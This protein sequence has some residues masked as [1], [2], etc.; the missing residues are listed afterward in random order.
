[1]RIAEHITKLYLRYPTNG[2]SPIDDNIMESAIV[3]LGNITRFYIGMESLL[4]LDKSEELHSIHFL[5]LIEVYLKGGVDCRL[6]YLSAI[7]ANC[8]PKP[9]ARKALLSDKGEAMKTI[10]KGLLSK[11]PVRIIYTL[12]M[13]EN[14]LIDKE[15]SIGWVINSKAYIYCLYVFILLCEGA[16]DAA[17][18]SYW[19]QKIVE[20]PII[21]EVE[22]IFKKLGE[23]H[24]KNIR[25]HSLEVLIAMASNKEIKEDMENN[26][27]SSI[28]S[29]LLE[30]NRIKELDENLVMLNS[31]LV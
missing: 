16:R 20:I 13:M 12:M 1:M 30:K 29:I 15:Q 3:S 9:E 18:V 22:H 28:V 10:V 17:F 19:L 14:C 26:K 4:Q 24:A 27:A 11:S 21:P 6:D 25:R 31:K 5:K 7:I 8:C 2:I 23:E